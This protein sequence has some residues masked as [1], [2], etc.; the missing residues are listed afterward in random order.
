MIGSCGVRCACVSVQSPGVMIGNT[1]AVEPV[2]L[3]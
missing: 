1:V 2:S 3:D